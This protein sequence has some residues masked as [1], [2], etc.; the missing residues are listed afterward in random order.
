MK[1]NTKYDR[2][3][4]TVLAMEC[5]SETKKQYTLT[6]HHLRNLC[7]LVAQ[8]ERNICADIADQHSAPLVAAKIRAG[9]D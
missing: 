5:V 3:I 1:Y 8:M 6:D 9:G 4:N 2:I 7:E